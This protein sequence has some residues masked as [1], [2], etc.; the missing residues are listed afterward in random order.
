MVDGGNK[1]CEFNEWFTSACQVKIAALAGLSVERGLNL[2]V[3][4]Q[5]L[6][7]QVRQVPESRVSD[8]IIC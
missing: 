2:I 3:I 7:Q 4:K 1:T 5:P 6:C 8:N